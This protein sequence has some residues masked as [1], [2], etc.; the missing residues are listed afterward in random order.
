MSAL[1]VCT[2]DISFGWALLGPQELLWKLLEA[3][4]VPRID[5]SSGFRCN[6]D[7]GRLIFMPW[8]F[9]LVCRDD[10]LIGGGLVLLYYGYAVA[11]LQKVFRY[12][13]DN[14]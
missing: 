5:S 6:D 10:I 8:K 13:A 12:I 1:A 3:A 2:I 7:R 4:K 11:A 14:R 9:D